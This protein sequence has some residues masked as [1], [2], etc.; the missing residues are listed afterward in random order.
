MFIQSLQMRFALKE[1]RLLKKILG[2][3][4]FAFLFSFPFSLSLSNHPAHPFQDI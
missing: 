1:F 4:S 3:S 2:S